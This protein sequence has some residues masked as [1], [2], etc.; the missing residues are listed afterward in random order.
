MSFLLITTRLI[1]SKKFDLADCTTSTN[2]IDIIKA[3]KLLAND[4]KIEIFNK[5]FG[6]NLSSIYI[7]N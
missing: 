3:T 6:L 5:K 4:H 2:I 1:F 7:I